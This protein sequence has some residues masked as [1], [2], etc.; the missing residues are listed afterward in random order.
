MR[1][2]I[3]VCSDCWTHSGKMKLLEEKHEITADEKLRTI[4]LSQIG[5]E[6]LLCPCGKKSTWFDMRSFYREGIYG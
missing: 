2:R 5:H 6:I 1:I 4:I 3:Y